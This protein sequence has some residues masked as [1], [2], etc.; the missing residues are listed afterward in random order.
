VLHRNWRWL[1]EVH[2]AAKVMKNSME[3]DP[4]DTR[5]QIVPDIYGP[6]LSRAKRFLDYAHAAYRGQP[7]PFPEDN[8]PSEMYAWF[9]HSR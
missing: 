2:N 1:E 9:I 5:I 3:N 8:A 4:Y 6:A 7:Q